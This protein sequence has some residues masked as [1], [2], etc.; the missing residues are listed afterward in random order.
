ME[1]LEVSCD[2]CGGDRAT[3]F[4]EGTD[5]EYQTTDEVF[6]FRRCDD[7]GYIYLNPRPATSELKTIYPSTYYS[8]VQ[9]ENRG[10]GGLM[11]DL[12]AKYHSHGLRRHLGKL[13]RGKGTAKVLEVGCGDGRFLDLM[14]LT[15]GDAIETYGIDFDQ[16]S[17]DAASAQGHH[18][19][20]GTFEES[21]YPEDFFDIIYISHVIEHVASPRECLEKCHSILKEGGG[22][23]VE[24]PNVD[25][26]EARLFRRT[27]WGGYHFPRHWHLFSP[28]T[29]AR[30]AGEC[31]LTVDSIHFG[32]SPVFLN[33]TFHHILWDRRVLR[34]LSELFSVTGIYKNNLHAL[35]LLLGFAVVERGLRLFS[36]GRG[37]NMIALLV[38]G[39]ES[40]GHGGD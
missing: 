12:R 6:Y 27:Y 30:L 31:R 20:V 1:V 24:T 38:K 39:G 19:E 21:N 10:S 34:P 9:R 22:V 4:S 35:A 36:H 37:S 2:L 18:V 23:C 8:Y 29:L 14:R 15:F 33:W 11:G 32:T 28:E 7:C 16:E 26:A 17:I 25:C 13:V 3:K 40:N 5:Y